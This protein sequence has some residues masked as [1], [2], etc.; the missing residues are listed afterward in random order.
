MTDDDDGGRGARAAGGAKH[1]V[2]QREPAA[3]CRTFGSADFMR[4]PF[5]GGQDD[6][7]EVCDEVRVR[8]AIEA[9]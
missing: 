1:V 4:V 7:V 6:D 3:W 8:Q 2:D 9:A 5:P